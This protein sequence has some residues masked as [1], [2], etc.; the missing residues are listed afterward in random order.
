MKFFLNKKKL[1]NL[2]QDNF[3]RVTFSKQ[4]SQDNKVLAKKL[5]PQVAGGDSGA[6]RLV[7]SVVQNIVAVCVWRSNF[8]I[9]SISK[10][11]DWFTTILF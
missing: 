9:S 3:F 7:A 2:S 10:L 11:N 5:T 8:E 4:L 1:K 6:A